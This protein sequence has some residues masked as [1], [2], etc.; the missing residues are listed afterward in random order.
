MFA[1]CASGMRAWCVPEGDGLQLMSKLDLGHGYMS[2]QKV[3]V[4]TC[5]H[6]HTIY[7]HTC[8]HTY[9][10]GYTHAHNKNYY[11]HTHK[12]TLTHTYV[13]TCTPVHMCTHMPHTPTSLY[14][15]AVGQDYY[16]AGPLSGQYCWCRHVVPS[17]V[18][19]EISTLVVCTYHFFDITLTVYSSFVYRC[20]STVLPCTLAVPLA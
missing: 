5:M 18:Q 4:Y 8:T 19:S 20:S 9:M 13:Y 2:S 12:C 17:M 7:I 1:D 3:C 10:H 16:H 6:M 11:M 14:F 15:T